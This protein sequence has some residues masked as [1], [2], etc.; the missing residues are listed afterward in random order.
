MSVQTEI[1]KLPESRVKIA[2]TVNPKEVDDKVERSAQAFGRE[3]RVPGFR[4]GKVPAPIV[5]RQLGRG[6][7]L[8]QALRDSLPGWYEQAIIHSGVTP[9]GEPSLDVP[10]TPEASAPLEFTIEIGIRPDAELGDY[11]G[12]EVAKAK[13]EVPDDAIDAEIERV[14]ESLAGLEAVERAAAEGDR[15]LMDFEGKI[16]DEPIEGGSATDFLYELG[17]GTLIDGF[18]AQLAGAEAGEERTV[19]TTFPSDYNAEHLA[20]KD[21]VFEVTVK[22]VREKKLPDLDDDFAA[23][24]SD[25]ETLGEWRADIEDRL[26]HSIEHR[27]EDQFREDAVD[28]AV[29][30]ATID[31]PE[32]I[33]AARATE[34]WERIERQLQGSGMDPN[35]YLQ[36][37]G[38]TREEAIEEARE[39]AEQSIR[40][41]AVLAAVAGA[42]EIEISEEEMLEALEPPAGEKGK[43]DKLLKRLRKEGRDVLL[44]E[45]LK[46]RKASDVIVESAVAIEM[47]AAEAH[48]RLWGEEDA[49]ESE[50]EPAR[51]EAEAEDGAATAS[52]AEG[53]AAEGA[54][55]SNNTSEEK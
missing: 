37:Q 23:D 21:A 33:A 3:M 1:S 28:A 7:V 51:E 46:M 47:D 22:E 35:A 50:G 53:T 27:I 13:P 4:K 54:E 26:K 42:E 43:P 20:G 5:L 16:D 41:E 11:K 36:M 25:F 44:A 17:S 49:D 10:E 48:K 6:P 14:R 39:D 12:L 30:A 15:L 8:E 19:E 24:N 40:R 29:E 18:D 34:L 31:V 52:E 45:D 32:P 9:V 2:V 55:A 38:K